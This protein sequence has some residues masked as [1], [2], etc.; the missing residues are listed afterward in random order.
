MCYWMLLRDGESEGEQLLSLDDIDKGGFLKGSFYWV[1]EVLVEG[2]WIK[3]DDFQ[4]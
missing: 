1:E 2:K 4:K 3:W